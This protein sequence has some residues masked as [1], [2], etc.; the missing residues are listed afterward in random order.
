MRKKKKHKRLDQV[1]AGPE[2]FGGVRP[3]AVSPGLRGTI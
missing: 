3:G 1:F 2:G